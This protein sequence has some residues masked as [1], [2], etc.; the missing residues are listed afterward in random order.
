MAT[1]EERK[2]KKKK[3]KKK[4]SRRER[5]ATADEERV[6]LPI[7]HGE[8]EF[9]NETSALAAPVVVQA[10]EYDPTNEV[11]PSSIPEDA[12]T[13]REEGGLFS[14]EGLA[15]AMVVDTATE[16]EFIY[17]A[18]E[19]DP[20]SKPPLHKNRRFR[21]YTCIALVIVMSVVV[22]VVVYITK[23]AKGDEIVNLSVD[24]TPP[25]T[26]APTLAPT[27][28]REASGIKEQIETGVL[29]RGVTFQDLDK[30]DPRW[31][32]LDWILFNDQMQLQSNDKN[33]YQRYV[34]AL[35]AYSFDSLAWS[36]CGEHREFDAKFGNVTDEYVVENCTVLDMTGD[37]E[38]HGVWL[39]S[40]PECGWYGAICSSDDVLRGLQLIGNSLIGEIPPE[41]SQLRFLQ[42]LAFNG[43]CLYGTI[44]PEISTMPNL[45]SL[46]LQG[47]G[48]SGYMP[49]E[50]YDATKLQLLNVAMQY[51]YSYE[52]T[53]S[54]GTKVYTLFAR[55]DPQNGY[56]WGLTGNVLGNQTNRWQSMKGLH[57]F[58]NSF[59]GEIA[60]EIGE[61]KYLVFLRAHSNQFYGL[62]PSGMTQL[63]KVREVYLHQNSLWSDIPPD[64]GQMEDLE[65]IRLGENRM[66]NPIPESFYNLVKIKNVWLQDTLDCSNVTNECEPSPDVGF[67]GTIQTEIGNLKEL[68]QLILNN[69]PFNG[70][71]PSEL[72]NCEK[73]SILHIH[74]TNI[75]GTVPKSVCLLRDKMLNIE[76]DTGIFYADCRPNNKTGDPW[77]SCSC[78]TDCCDH[79]TRVCIADD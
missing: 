67:E 15:V 78:C 50:M 7:D 65:D 29:Q 53:R 35:L 34:M 19:Y 45:L 62:I 5:E 47:N 76:T 70:T 44:P 46:E 49:V 33:L 6:P 55:G 32:A 18:I 10:C 52:C 43:N 61:L 77:I 63:K 20:D 27:T 79:T 54:N 14:E 40:T 11:I 17:A 74:Q 38:Q 13:P 25:P 68:S 3:D 69:N 9:N 36:Y 51:D 57:L 66:Y 56:N 8:A 16:D 21:L 37:E 71:L 2:K 31:L 41:I 58:D 73:L 24:Y 72:G 39:S 26:A 75:E 23:S 48:L 22:V 30:N 4:K 1:E 64:I 60:D 42:Y 12:E 59:T 28:D